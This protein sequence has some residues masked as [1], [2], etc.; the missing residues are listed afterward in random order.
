MLATAVRSC[1]ERVLAVEGN[2]SD[3]TLDDVGID[4]DPAIIDEAQE[5]VPAA[6]AITDRFG[7][8]ALPGDGRELC[9]EPGLRPSTTGFARC[10]PLVWSRI[11]SPTIRRPLRSSFVPNV[12]ALE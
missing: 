1:E 12:S 9:F 6:Q 7:D 8:R 4:L 11:P 10:W 2:R 5:T 3:G